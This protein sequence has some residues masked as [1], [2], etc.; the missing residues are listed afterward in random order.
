M[1]GREI[2]YKIRMRFALSFLLM[3]MLAAAAV[4]PP[5]PDIGYPL[6][7]IKPRELRSQFKDK[8]RG[9]I[10]HAID[11]MRHRGTPVLAVT[12]GTIRKLYRSRSGG[13]SIYLFDGSEQYCFFYGHLDHYAKGLHEGQE[14]HR[15]ELIGYV[16][17]T[18]NAKRN[19]PHLHFAVSLTGP[20][21]QWSGGV[22]ID[23]F[24]MLLSVTQPPTPPAAESH[25]VVVA[26]EPELPEHP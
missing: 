1:T 2:S 8:R 25:P 10:H 12:D 15:G 7:D 16:G 6:A 9:H 18:G 20:R 14:V 11:L 4:A 17:Y 24:P 19:A 22:P 21:R 23:P 5:M 26:D 3:R 13:I